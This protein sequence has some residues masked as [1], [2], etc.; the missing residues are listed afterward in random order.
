MNK[1]FEDSDSDNYEDEED[2]VDEGE[3]TK[4]LFCVNQ[5][6][7]IELAIQ[8]LD[9]S[10]KIQLAKLKGKFNMDQYSYIK[11]INYIRKEKPS[12]EDILSA[13]SVIWNDEKYL[14]PGDY[15]SWLSYDFEEIVP[16]ETVNQPTETISVEEYKKMQKIVATLSNKIKDHERILEHAAE[17]VSKMRTA[18]HR[19]VDK[20]T[21]EKERNCVSS[22]SVKADESYFSSYSHFGIHHEMLSDT[23]RT[24]S[25]RDSLLKNKEFINGKTIMDLGCGTSVLSIFASQAGAKQIVAVDN[26]EVIY[27]AMDIAKK[28][29]ISNISFVKGRLE[30]TALPVEKFDVIISEWM[31]YFL[32]FE[33]MLDS[34]IYARDKHLNEGGL[35]MPNRCTMSIVG[36]GDEPLH[37][38]QIKFWDSVYGLD[39]SVMKKEVLHEPLID[40][41]NSEHVLTE[42]NVIADLD[43]ATVTV[44]YS[45]FTYD[46]KLQCTKAGRL[47]SFVGYFDTFFGGLPNP[48]EFSTS[49][50]AEPTHWK[51]VVFFLEKPVDVSVGEVV[52][53]S[54]VCR[55]SKQS[56][57]SLDVKITAFGKQQT[58][59]LD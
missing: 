18:Y 39:M 35:L 43:L 6:P 28:N 17:S 54:L 8:H 48:V 51:Q 11:F 29:N 41:V 50:F 46:F 22:V 21:V 24:I 57:R 19:L 1:E 42:P 44:D 14:K 59:Y 2:E 56:M 36:Y 58:Y 33:G 27:N 13:K 38:R 12:P 5:F 15:E 53:G 47:T 7:S 10:H 34:V 16:D 20:E 4:C 49:P 9:G 26:S 37:N 52:S 32:L 45:N 25:Y 3:T 31:G 30:D 40:V 55:R 23:V